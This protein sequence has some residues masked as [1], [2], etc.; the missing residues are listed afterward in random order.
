M[1]M[2][3]AFLVCLA[4]FQP[5]FAQGSTFTQSDYRWYQNRNGKT[6]IIPLANQ[7][8]AI[9]GIGLGDVIRLRMNV[10][11]SDQNLA[12][13]AQ[14]FKLQF[15]TS[16]SGPWTDVGATGSA[17]LWRAYDNPNV[18]DGATLIQWLRLL[19]N[20]DVAESYEED[21][22]SV[23]NPRAIDINK[24]GEWDWVL[25]NNDAAPNII[26]Y[27]RMVQSDGTPLDGYTRHP[28]ATTAEQPTGPPVLTQ[29]TYRWYYNRDGALPFFPLEDENQPYSAPVLEGQCR[30][31]M[32]VLVTDAPLTAGS[33]SFKLQFTTSTSGPWTDVGAIGSGSVW[34]GYDNPSP[35]DG[36]TLNQW[37]KLLSN[38]DTTESYEEENPSVSNPRTIDMN[39]RAEWDW[40]LDAN[41]AATNTTYYFRM[42]E[43]DGDALSAYN[44]YPQLSTPS[45]TVGSTVSSNSGSGNPETTVSYTNTITN[46][47][48]TADTFDVTT[49]SSAGWS[50][51]LYES[52]GVTPLSDTDGDTIPDTGSLNANQAVNIV[53]KVTVGWNTTSD[54][55]TVIST[56]SVDSQVSDTGTNI[57][58]AP[59]TVSIVVSDSSADFGTDLTPQGQDSNSSDVVTDLQGTVGNQGSYYAWE[60]SG[61]AGVSI[62]VKS[63]KTWNGTVD[64]SENSGTSSTMPIDSG[65]LRH[66]ESVP[67]SYSAC[68][69]TMAFTT[70]V[71]WQSNV[72]AGTNT[73]TYYYCLRVDWDDDPGTFASTVTYSVSQ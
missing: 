34:R 55:T 65:V 41:N 16:T 24:R 15:A 11:V 29:D 42:M 44:R 37:L 50:V 12:A 56:S 49:S 2:A 59:P 45:S 35:A 39:E 66:S 61:G 32:N 6:P 21:N 46:V 60:A 1:A 73:Y 30:L 43:S 7:N 68:A 51:A 69:G 23:P 3:G 53:V 4:S 8:T 54:T 26:Y 13:G 20:S 31:R 17:A 9:T 10:L 58:T 57:T 36:Q 63:N 67:G 48:Q 22:P 40:V 18:N 52:D 71:T 38:S 14:Q 27:F 25:Q 33:R 70:S 72:G 47:G 28:Q 64:A 5:A 62:T 19:S